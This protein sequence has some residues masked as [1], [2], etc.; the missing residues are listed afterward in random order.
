[1]VYI[2]PQITYESEKTKW[3]DEGCLSC[4]WK[5]G[6]VKRHVEVSIRAYNEKGELFEETASGLLAHIFQH[7]TDHL[8]GILFVDK[9][10]NVRDMT[11]QEINQSQE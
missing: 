5:L 6:Q 3:L 4:R 1:L 8:H 9:A 7:E 11:E 2:N 10:R